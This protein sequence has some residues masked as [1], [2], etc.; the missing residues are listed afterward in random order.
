MYVDCLDRNRQCIFFCKL[1]GCLQ[2]WVVDKYDQKML[3]E[4]T[5]LGEMAFF[6]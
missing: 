2:K 6:E 3:D 5:W 1:W 4:V